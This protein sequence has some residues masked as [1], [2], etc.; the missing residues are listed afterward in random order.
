MDK[1]L[2]K[3]LI[4]DGSYALHRALN[5]PGLQELQ[6]VK[7]QKT[8][9]VFGVLRIMI[10]EIK[11]FPGYFPIFCFD[12]GLSKRRLDLHPNYKHNLQ[13]QEADALIA[14]DQAEEDDYL[15]EYRRQREDL[16]EI[17]KSL[18]IPS[19][20]IPGWEGDD[21]QYLVSRV[22]EDAVIVSDDKDMITLLS[23]TV[24]I[25]RSLRDETIDWNSCEDYY[26][27][28]RY[29]IRKSIIGDK[30][31]NIPQVAKG[32]GEKAADEIASLLCSYEYSTLKDNLTQLVETMKPSLKKK[33]DLVLEN[34]EQFDTNY[35]LTDLTLV[36]SPAG[37]E[38]LLKTLITETVK[39]ANV[40]KAF[41]LLIYYD[42]KS[43]YPDQVLSLLSGSR[44]QVIK[45]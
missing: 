8:G 36:E 34:W 25:R 28:P 45:S 40:L 18:G 24:K 35:K 5:A 42:I 23:P 19:L 22:S 31:D 44:S 26:K 21:L 1:Y 20:I 39:K 7:G 32:V 13:R 14:A 30:S 9:G 16:I 11:N 4:F 12:K 10:S 6:N 41:Q 27:N 38:S 43:I 2:N 3:I 17:L 29:I 15:K 33:A 37:F